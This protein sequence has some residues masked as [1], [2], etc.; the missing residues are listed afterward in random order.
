MVAIETVTPENI[1]V[2]KEARLRALQD[3]PMA[4]G[5]TYARESQ[6]T[7]AEWMERARQS[8]GV[9]RVMYMAVDD[10]AVCGIAGAMRDEDDESRAALISMWTAPTHRKKSV[11]RML[12]EEV[13]LWARSRRVKVLTLM[14]T[15]VNPTAM[16]FY[17]QLGF[18]RTGRTEPYPNDAAVIEYEMAMGID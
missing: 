3:S 12:V 14:V 16:R 5:A 11:G 18:V 7:D 1:F 6:L 13:I 17:E 15:S 2:F 10:G 8:D 4:F 9:K